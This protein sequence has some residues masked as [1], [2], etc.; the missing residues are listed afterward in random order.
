MLEGRPGTAGMLEGCRDAGGKVWQQLGCWRDAG[1]LEGRSGTAGM[2]EGCRD[3]GGKAWHS[4]DAGGMPGCWREG[5]AQPGCWRDAG[6]LEGRSG[7]AGMLEGCRD[8]GGKRR[9]GG[10]PA[11]AGAEGAS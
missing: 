1:M 4:W 11:A 10:S 9:G 6:M 2:L 8:A 5:L 3:A 7:T